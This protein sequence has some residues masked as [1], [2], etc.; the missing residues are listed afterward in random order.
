MYIIFS[1]YLY[2][3]HILSTLLNSF[4]NQLFLSYL[5]SYLRKFLKGQV[6]CNLFNRQTNFLVAASERLKTV[7]SL[8]MGLSLQLT[9]QPWIVTTIPM[10]I[11]V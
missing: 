7:C 6:E 9:L 10:I 3:F 4:S 5:F 2:I 8:A 11:I 1:L